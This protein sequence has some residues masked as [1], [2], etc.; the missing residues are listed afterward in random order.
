MP[1]ISD[2]DF[3]K[4]KELMKEREEKKKRDEASNEEYLQTLI[5]KFEQFKVD[6]ANY[7]TIEAMALKF[8]NYLK[9][10]FDRTGEDFIP[11]NWLEMQRYLTSKVLTKNEKGQVDLKRSFRN[12]LRDYGFAVVVNRKYNT[13]KVKKCEPRKRRKR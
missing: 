8:A 3:E 4:F 12:T 13:M 2:E 6:Y 9:D 11:F 5:G 1:Y 10:Y 7:G